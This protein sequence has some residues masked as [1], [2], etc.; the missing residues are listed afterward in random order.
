[1][2]AFVIEP[3]RTDRWYLIDACLP[4]GYSALRVWAVIRFGTRECCR[5]P[6]PASLKGRVFELI[7]RPADEHEL[8]IEVESEQGLLATEV[9]TVK[10][11][12][13]PV[14]WYWMWRRVLG[15][16]PGL[17]RQKAKRLGI[18]WRRMLSEPFNVYRLLGCL[19]YH[20][21]AP[22]YAEW[23]TQYWSC[24]DEVKQR[25]HRHLSRLEVGTVPVLLDARGYL[26]HDR[27]TEQQQL[28]N[29]TR[30]SVH[31]QIGL[32]TRL[33][34]LTENSHAR[35]DELENWVLL[36][37]PGQ[38][39]EPWALA[40]LLTEA[41][42]FPDATL[43][44]S[45]HALLQQDGT[46]VAPCFK[47]DWSPELQRVSHYVGGCLFV[48]ASV[49]TAVRE[50]L[51]Y[52][53]AAY[54]LVLEVGALSNNDQIRH[55]PAVLWHQTGE[56]PQ[57]YAELLSAHLQRHNID[58]QVVHDDRGH[59]RIRYGLPVDKPRI[60]I[61][62]P[63][64]D[65]L[66]FLQPCV[67][68]ILQKT[69]W[70]DYEVLILD[71]Q[72]SCP[73]TLAYMTAVSS[74]PRVHVLAYD[75]P[76]NFSAIN[77]F[78]VEHATGELVCMLNNDTEVISPDWLNE[79]ASRLLQP[80]VGAVGARLYFSDGRVQHAGDVIGPGGCAN[81]LH[82]IIEADDPGYMNRAVLPQELSAVTAACLLTTRR[83]YKEL[84]GLDEH[85][86]TVAFNDVDFCLRIREA[87]Y[88]VVYTPYAELYH[89]ESVSRGKDDNPEKQARAKREVQYMRERWA[90]V[91]ERDPYYN[92]NLNYAKPDFT[93]GKYPRVDWP[94]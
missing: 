25:L 28:L 11:V 48:K 47:P 4:S 75:H 74:D 86:L 43:I 80:G 60:S 69:V 73:D 39:L 68:S 56:G 58:A 34:V 94:W 76:F 66:H 8:T 19:R 54:E 61:I 44:Y 91:I 49:L 83:L 77:N 57:V 29:Q 26:G 88:R 93:L 63:T 31:A 59:L 62:I 38:R 6:L 13:G 85:N 51:G 32:S 67:D 82:G 21:P 30:A 52:M 16:L 78:A 87:G 45:D 23:R 15:A 70:P 92:P 9:I 18:G 12:T 36:I 33:H 40:W 46:A 1:M 90:D 14:A 37:Q 41:S 27:Q 84:G 22:A 5:I 17:D 2:N 72:S 65:M 81:H 24:A 42:R 71:N 64:R 55:I 20:F 3:Y 10:T 53:P 79:M 50:R 89:H 7:P 35:L